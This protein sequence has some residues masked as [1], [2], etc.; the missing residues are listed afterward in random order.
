M[1]SFSR[2]HAARSRWG[3][4]FFLTSDRGALHG[5]RLQDPRRRY[6]S[7]LAIGDPRVFP[8]R[9][10]GA[11]HEE[12]DSAVELPASI[13]SK[14]ANTIFAATGKLHKMLGTAGTFL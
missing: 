6:L 1:P 12:R 10:G 3:D 11:K 5:I 2:S 14:W 8:R 7:S 4:Q 9:Q 13:N